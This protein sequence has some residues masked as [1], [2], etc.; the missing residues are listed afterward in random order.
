MLAA[1][2]ARTRVEVVTP[3]EKPYRQ[4]LLAGRG[5]S[6]RRWAK[7]FDAAILHCRRLD[8]GKID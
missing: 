4:C 8:P 7:D 6:E 2:Q 5:P 1:A 3:I